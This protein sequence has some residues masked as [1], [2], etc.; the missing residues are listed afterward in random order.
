MDATPSGSL[1]SIAQTGVVAFNQGP[2]ISSDPIPPAK[3]Y[4]ENQVFGTSLRISFQSIGTGRGHA[5]SSVT[6][7]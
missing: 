4:N 5:F 7:N 1:D 6:L 3:F 2:F